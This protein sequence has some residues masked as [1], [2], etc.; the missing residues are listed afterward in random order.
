MSMLSKR[1]L[2]LACIGAQVACGGGVARQTGNGGGAVAV[3]LN[4]APAAEVHGVRGVGS[5]D[6]PSFGPPE[7]Y[8]PQVLVRDLTP[9]EIA[10]NSSAKP[11]LGASVAAP[12]V[13]PTAETLE[14]AAHKLPDEMVMFVLVLPD[15]AFAWD[16]FRT[17][18]GADRQALISQRQSD[19]APSQKPVLEKL[20]AMSLTGAPIW[21]ANIIDVT[22]PA[23]LAPTLATWPEI[24]SLQ[25][26]MPVE[27]QG[28]PVGAGYYGG[29]RRAAIQAQRLLN[30]MP[31]P[32]TGAK[33]DSANSSQPVR[34]GDVGWYTDNN[35]NLNTVPVN[36]PGFL[37]TLRGSSRFYADQD[38]N[39]I[40]KNC[41][42]STDPT[43][44]TH[45]TVVMGVMAGA[46]TAGQDPNFT[47]TNTS[48]QIDRSGIAPNAQIQYYHMGTTNSADI[49]Y[50]FQQAVADG[51]DIL[52]NSWGFV[53]GS[54]F[55]PPSFDLSGLNEIIQ[56][57]YNAGVLAVVSSGDNNT[58]ALAPGFS[59]T[60]NETYPAN[61]PEV[62]SVGGTAT[63]YNSSGTTNSSVSM[64]PS[65]WATS[66]CAVNALNSAGQY[67]TEPNNAIGPVAPGVVGLNYFETSP[68]AT[69]GY[70]AGTSANNWTG[71]SFAAP[72][73]AGAAGL[74]RHAFL[75]DVPSGGVR[76]NFWLKTDLTMLTDGYNFSNYSDNGTGFLSGGTSVYSGTGHLQMHSPD[77]GSFAN[78][79]GWEWGSATIGPN[80]GFSEVL[81]ASIASQSGLHPTQH[82]RIAL[83]WEET[84]LTHV[85]DIDMA[86]DA[87]NPSQVVCDS[88]FVFQNDESI[89]N[90]VHATAANI[91]SCALPNGFLQ[92]RFYSYAIPTGQTRTVYYS[93]LQDTD[94]G[95]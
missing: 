50:A 33:G 32:F 48:A 74:L 42:A 18:N 46:I 19:L 83:F 62:L 10:A 15:V 3:A 28:N 71:S 57:A 39:S 37:K 35:G 54:G 91:P 13:T 41:V 52:N 2:L 93:I 68:P 90:S 34:L 25:H 78:P 75:V 79:W 88:G 17:A 43:K 21:L 81:T 14:W 9:E 92:F 84:D 1:T 36:H 56:N 31:T 12:N 7:P 23:Y 67:V 60:C 76:Q 64:A 8:T 24:G 94:T 80:Q 20:A 61:R 45:D 73:V 38:C 22:A 4:V 5:G 86:V 69:Y 89:I 16:S 95:Y 87:L 85:A 82:L 66:G 47:G 70:T 77:D 58:T 6:S 30:S 44:Q 53:P 49:A 55:A 51:V 11:Q 27:A 72:I 26:A 40:T 65:A 29:D 59:T 63:V